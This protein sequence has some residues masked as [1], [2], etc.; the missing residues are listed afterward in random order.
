MVG[1]LICRSVDEA[2]W[3]I[4]RRQRGKY[5][6]DPFT[7]DGAATRPLRISGLTGVLG[8]MGAEVPV[9]I[10][11]LAGGRES[12]MVESFLVCT[13]RARWDQNDRFV[14]VCKCYLQVACDDYRSLPA[15]GV[16]SELRDVSGE[17][18]PE[19]RTARGDARSEGV[20]EGYVG[21]DDGD[22][23][24]RCRHSHDASSRVREVTSWY[25]TRKQGV[26]EGGLNGNEDTA[27]TRD[28]VDCHVGITCGEEQIAGRW[29]LVWGELYLLKEQHVVRL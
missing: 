14:V 4:K 28:R 25:V 1:I 20:T 24:V 11:E 13:T 15:G 29:L 12:V 7:C 21:A 3:R 2:M 27:A 10:D 19:R 26:H 22:R 18:G 5:V 6:V 16:G 9:R 23:G 8:P 17:M